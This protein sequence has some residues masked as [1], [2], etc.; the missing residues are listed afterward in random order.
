MNAM[1]GRGVALAAPR[2]DQRPD[3]PGV[4]ARDLRPR[5]VVPRETD[6]AY[7]VTM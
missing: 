3:R 1:L 7:Y 4:R 2:A 6:R 5:G